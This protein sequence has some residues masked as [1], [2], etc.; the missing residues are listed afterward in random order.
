MNTSGVR[1]SG[2]M[3]TVDAL[4]GGDR[5]WSDESAVFAYCTVDLATTI[6]D[7]SFKHCRREANK[8][9]HELARSC[10]DIG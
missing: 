8:V 1:L 4:S 6:G 3:E 5:W 10:F 7:V 9:P 2:D